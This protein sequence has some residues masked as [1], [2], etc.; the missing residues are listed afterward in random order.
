MTVDLTEGSNV[1]LK[2]G[3]NPGDLV[4]IDGEEKLKPYG[5]VK[6]Q[7][8]KSNADGP[9]TQ[10]IG[11]DTGSSTGTAQPD[12]PDQGTPESGS[13]QS[14]PQQQKSGSGKRAAAQA[15]SQAG[16]QSGGPQ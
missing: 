11:S 14:R 6:P 10:Q 15:G 7:Q 9:S 2:G 8:G 4:V 16:S 5:R 1:I 3:V 12:S 13:Q